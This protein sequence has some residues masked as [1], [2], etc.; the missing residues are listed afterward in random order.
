MP[1][2]QLLSKNGLRRDH[3]LRRRRVGPNGT[4]RDIW[5]L[6]SSRRVRHLRTSGVGVGIP[7][8]RRRLQ[9]VDSARHTWR[10][11]ETVGPIGADRFRCFAANVHDTSGPHSDGTPPSGIPGRAPMTHTNEI[12]ISVLIAALCFRYS[13]ED[14]RRRSSGRARNRCCPLFKSVLDRSNTNGSDGTPPGGRTR[15]NGS[16]L[17]CASI[18]PEASLDPSVN[19]VTV[20]FG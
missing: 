16:V 12:G 7:G 17:V 13:A 14:F 5:F 18:Q 10:R 11:A 6:G 3:P 15:T 19:R 4:E 9:L 8:R 1:S 2:R 20:T